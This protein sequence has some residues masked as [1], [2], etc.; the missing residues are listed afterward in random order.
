MDCLEGKTFHITK[1]TFYYP[2]EADTV[3]IAKAKIDSAIY[4]YMMDFRKRKAMW[5]STEEY[6]KLKKQLA[7]WDEGNAI[8]LNIKA[9]SLCEAVSKIWFAYDDWVS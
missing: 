6:E 7:H 5:I 4:Y 1:M 9:H 3:V 8:N 2:N